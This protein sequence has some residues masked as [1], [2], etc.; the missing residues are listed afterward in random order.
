MSKFEITDD[1]G[2]KTLS[3]G[4]TDRR[5]EPE[6][7]VRKLNEKIHRESKFADDH[8]NLPFKFSKPKKSKRS[9]LVKCS[10]CNLKLYVPINTVGMICKECNK[11]VSV[12]NI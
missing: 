1:L 12:E 10:L 5:W 3:P 7:G 8:K 9:K 6:G 4:S 2:T 11:F